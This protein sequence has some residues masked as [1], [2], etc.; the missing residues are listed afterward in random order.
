M[1]APRTRTRRTARSRSCCGPPVVTSPLPFL[2][3]LN[4]LE[5]SAANLE[6]A[7]APGK[8]W[9]MITEKSAIMRD[10]TMDVNMAILKEQQ[11][12][13]STSKAERQWKRFCEWKRKR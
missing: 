4:P 7:A 5:L 10:R 13:A 12:K 11:T 3:K 9:E 6:V 1:N 8:T 2:S